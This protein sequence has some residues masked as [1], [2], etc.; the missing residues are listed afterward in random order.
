[1]KFLVARPEDV[2]EIGGLLA[3]LRREI[4]RTS[5]LLMPDGTTPE[6][7]HQRAG[8][9]AGLCRDHGCRHAP[10]LHIELYGNR[11]GT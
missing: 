10:R 4:P 2:E 6:V 1:L 9:L 11:R 7:R 5:V 3:G 8:W